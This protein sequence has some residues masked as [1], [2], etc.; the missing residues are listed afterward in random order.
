MARLKRIVISLTGA[1]SSCRRLPAAG[2]SVMV[3]LWGVSAVASGLPPSDPHIN[4]W[5]WN[6]HAPPVGWFIVDFIIFVFLLAKLGK[7]PLQTTFTGRHETIKRAISEAAARLGKAGST[8]ETCQAK[9]ASVDDEAT[10]MISSSR[11]DGRADCDRLLDEAKEY[12]EKMRRDSSRLMGQETVMAHARLQV[13]T[14]A[15]ALDKAQDLLLGEMADADHNR[16][17]EQAIDELEAQ[18]VVGGAR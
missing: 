8:R 7:K 3:L 5:E 6:E 10:G 9:L 11:D 15:K 12:A 1:V 18:S 17:I 4:V 13:E 2:L 16:L 14:V